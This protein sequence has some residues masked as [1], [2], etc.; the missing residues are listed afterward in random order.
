MQAIQIRAVLWNHI[1]FPFFSLFLAPAGVG[2][3]WNSADVS[4]GSTV[5]VLGLGAVG[6][7]VSIYTCFA[8]LN[9]TIKNLPD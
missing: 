4:A 7:A 3:A 9:Y 8:Q 6:L 2:A 1:Q 5:A